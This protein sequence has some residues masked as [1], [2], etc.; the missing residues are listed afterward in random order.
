MD[1]PTAMDR[2]SS[3]NP[4]HQ[5]RQLATRRK[6][7]SAD[8]VKLTYAGLRAEMAGASELAAALYDCAIAL[9]VR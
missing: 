8:V 9:A 1:R 3:A 5:N 7:I 4:S 6:G 2:A